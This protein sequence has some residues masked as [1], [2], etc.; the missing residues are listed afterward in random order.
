MSEKSID[1]CELLDIK[2]ITWMMK[3]L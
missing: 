3:S 2:P 1:F